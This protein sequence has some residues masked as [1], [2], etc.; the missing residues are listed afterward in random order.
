LGPRGSGRPWMRVV[1]VAPD[2]WMDTDVDQFPEGM[3]VPLAQH[4]PHYASVAIRVAGNPVDYREPLRR[5]LMDLDPNLPLD[6]LRSMAT[7]IH[8]RT[9]LYRRMGPMYMLLGSA[10]LVL[11]MVG[12]YGVM[13]YMVHARTREL[14]IRMALGAQRAAILRLV[15]RRGVMQISWGVVLGVAI[16]LQVSRGIS[17][18]VFQMTPWDPWVLGASFGA[19][20]LTGIAATLVPA[21]RAARVN[22]MVALRE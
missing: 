2:M 14:G 5:A 19:L 18:L 10:G 3:Y 13:A 4:D 9:S 17:R 21:R 15:L 7:L 8:D 16:A 22:P 11:A 1:G 20:A 6:E 12:L